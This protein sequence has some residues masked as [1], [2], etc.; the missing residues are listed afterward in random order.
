MIMS[1]FCDSQTIISN[2]QLINNGSDSYEI[3]RDTLQFTFNWDLSKDTI[4]CCVRDFN[5]G[6]VKNL[7]WIKTNQRKGKDLNYYE[8]VCGKGD[9]YELYYYKDDN[10]FALYNVTTGYFSYMF[11]KDVNVEKT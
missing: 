11:G 2:H 9:P 10:S 3:D 5:G 1:Y 8:I 6:F 7:K 4:I